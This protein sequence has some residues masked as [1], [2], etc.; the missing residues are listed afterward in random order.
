[1]KIYFE[2]G[3]LRAPFQLPFSDYYKVDASRGYSENQQKLDAIKQDVY[4]ATIYTNSLVALDNEY[5]W[6]KELEVP[7]L[8][9]RAGEHMVFTRVDNLTTRQLKEGHNLMKMYM[10]GEFEQKGQ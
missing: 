6:N 9:I 5:C 1:M 2:D 8:Y 4:N 3:E 10:A 7:E